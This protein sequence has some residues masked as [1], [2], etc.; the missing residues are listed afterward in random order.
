MLCMSAVEHKEANLVRTGIS[1][2]GDVTLSEAVY[3]LPTSLRVGDFTTSLSLC[4]TSLSQSSRKVCFSVDGSCTMCF[5]LDGAVYIQCVN[6]DTDAV[7]GSSLE[8][9]SARKITLS[10][11]GAEFSAHMP[12]EDPDVVYAAWFVEQ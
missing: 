5:T 9:C 6:P 2:D 8:M 4:S 11:S 3:A 12:A 10:S 7:K 1:D